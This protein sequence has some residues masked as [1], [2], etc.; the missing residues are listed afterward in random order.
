[1]RLRYA[2]MVGLG[3][4]TLAGCCTPAGCRS[5]Y[6]AGPASCDRRAAATQ[7]MPAV[8]PALLFANWIR[9]LDRR[10]WSRRIRFR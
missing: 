8:V 7:D 6:L 4:G 1:M 10:I 5:A 2:L 3:M 9:E